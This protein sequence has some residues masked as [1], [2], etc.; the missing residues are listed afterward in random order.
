MKVLLAKKNKKSIY[1]GKVPDIGELFMSPQGTGIYMR[2]DESGFKSIKGYVKKRLQIGCMSLESG[3][4]CFMDLNT[5]RREGFRLLR[6]VGGVLE[7]ERKCQ[8]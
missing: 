6:P 8:Y 2:I 7:V 5:S 3:R 1:Q 4:L